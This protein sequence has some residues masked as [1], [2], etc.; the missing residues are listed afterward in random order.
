[1][2]E[3]TC[4]DKASTRPVAAV[5]TKGSGSESLLRMNGHAWCMDVSR[6][7]S[8]KTGTADDRRAR[9]FARMVADSWVRK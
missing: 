3:P 5:V 9:I 7:D 4:I 1:M 2:K 6:A 8:G